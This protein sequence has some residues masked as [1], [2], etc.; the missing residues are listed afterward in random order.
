MLRRRKKVFQSR[1]G[2]SAVLEAVVAAPAPLM[3]APTLGALGVRAT[4]EV[5]KLERGT[6]TADEDERSANTKFEGR[7]PSW[8]V[9][10][11]AGPRC[12]GK[13]ID[14]VMVI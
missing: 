1:G 5:E 2:R 3:L 13:G 14:M 6:R 11:T 9:L 7:S 12:M 4:D 8:E 10:P